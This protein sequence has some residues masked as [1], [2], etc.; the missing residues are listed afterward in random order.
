M[1]HPKRK[2]S[3]ARAAS[4]RAN[5]KIRRLPATQECPNCGAD[6]QMHCACQTCGHYRGRAVLAREDY[7]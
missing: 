6:K 2:S 7:V 3:K 4:R 5:Y 1:A